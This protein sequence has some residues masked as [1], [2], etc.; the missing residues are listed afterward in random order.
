MISSKLTEYCRR[1]NFKKTPEPRKFQSRKNDR[2]IFV[3]QKHWATNLH[4]D[5][6]LEIGGVLKSWAVP[7]TPPRRAGIRRLALETEDHPLAYADFQGKIPAGNYGAGRVEIW[8]RGFFE[9]LDFKK[10]SLLDDYQ[11]GKI[12][13][14]LEGKKLK[15][16]YALIKM[17]G[18]GNHWLLLKLKKQKN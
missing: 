9:N 11:K 17:K 4:Y 10:K 18:R 8:D 3:V 1:R 14:F 5:F 15:G 13:F 2:P 6:R 7:K 16:G 12:E